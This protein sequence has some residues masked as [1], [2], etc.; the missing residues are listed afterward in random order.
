MQGVSLKDYCEKK[1]NHAKA[2][3]EKLVFKEGK[4]NLEPFEE[5]NI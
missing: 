4:A 5:E 2:R 1:L 3:I